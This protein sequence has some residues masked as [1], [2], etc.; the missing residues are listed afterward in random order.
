MEMGDLR[1]CE[2]W[3]EVW[4][5]GERLREAGETGSAG[6]DCASEGERLR[7]AGRD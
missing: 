5:G 3:E 7:M 6:R 1:D 2:W 4:S